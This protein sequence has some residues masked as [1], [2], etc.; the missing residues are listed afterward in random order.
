MIEEEMLD[1]TPQIKLLFD[2]SVNDGKKK[3][4]KT[5]SKKGKRKKKKGEMDEEIILP[6]FI[7][8]TPSQTLFLR[9]FRKATSLASK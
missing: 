5:K 1:T 3:L 8:Y 7:D 4:K 9:L 2:G 6:E